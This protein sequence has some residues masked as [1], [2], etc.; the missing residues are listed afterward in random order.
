M[1][2]KAKKLR[3]QCRR[4]MLELDMMLMPFVDSVFSSLNEQQQADFEKLLSYEDS[5]LFPWLMLR[6]R[7]DDPK[8]AAMVDVIVDYARKL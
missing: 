6:E 5:Q 2:D 3:W 4:G 7:P 8:M 1:E